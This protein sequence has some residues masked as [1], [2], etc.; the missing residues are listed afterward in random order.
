MILQ[1]GSNISAVQQQQVFSLKGYLSCCQPAQPSVIDWSRGIMVD[2]T[3]L[4]TI[5]IVFIGIIINPCWNNT[6]LSISLVGG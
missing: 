3:E 6:H 2:K 1:L 5:G 4:S